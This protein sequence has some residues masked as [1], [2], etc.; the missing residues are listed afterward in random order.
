LR[1][2][3]QKSALNLAKIEPI[4]QSPA[5]RVGASTEHVRHQII[6]VEQ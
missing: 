1:H 5:D 3:A 4:E 6:A 2:G